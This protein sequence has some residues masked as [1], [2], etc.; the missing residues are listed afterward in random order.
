MIHEDPEVERLRAAFAAPAGPAPEPDAC[1]APE[2]IWAAVRGELSASEVRE[3]IDHT[4]ACPA[5]AEDWRLAAALDRKVADG[6]AQARTSSPSRSAL[7]RPWL[8]AV[9]AVL[10]LGFVLVPVLR[11]DDPAPIYRGEDEAIQSALPAGEALP[12]EEAV[13]RWTGPAGAVY[14]VQV[15]TEDLRVVATAGG[16]ETPELRVPAEALRDLPSGAALLWR[17]EATLPDG[18]EMASVTFSNSLR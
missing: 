12:R 15:T 3:V 2:R 9:A 14:D 10:V 17:V 1:P 16:L 18:A 11:H 4:I 7:G 6:T 5:C 8:S 13:L